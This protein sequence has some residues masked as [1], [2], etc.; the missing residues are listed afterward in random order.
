MTTTSQRGLTEAHRQ[1]QLRLS[2]RSVAKAKIAYDRFLNVADLDASFP[3][4][5]V[6][7]QQIVEEGFLGSERLA[8]AYVVRTLK[9]AG[10]E[11]GG[12]PS[13]ALDQEKLLSNLLVNGPISIKQKIKKGIPAD[14][15]KAMARERFLGVMKE[16]VLDGG[17]DLIIGASKYHGKRGRWRRVTDGKPCAFCAMLA[18]RG[19]V[20]T[21]E[22]ARF[23]SH[24]NCGCTAELVVGD[25]TPTQREKL[26]RY[27]YDE[28]A[29]AAD[30]A[31]EKRLA[32]SV[33]KKRQQQDNILWRMRRNAPELF[34][35][36]VF[37]EV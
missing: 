25:W 33:A 9:D 15:A 32:P 18:G 4:W 10:L 23:E 29:L 11:V 5:A 37:P 19:P 36:G 35:D 34:S 17:R 6:L 8:T 12:L 26:W 22:S 20:Y 2:A 31:G 21:S 30:K 7:M 13:V 28:A 1:A 16:R 3:A 24:E 14:Q 27:S